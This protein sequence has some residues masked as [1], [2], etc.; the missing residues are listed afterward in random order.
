MD[1]SASTRRHAAFA[2]LIGI[3][4]SDITPPI[5]IYHR[6]WGTAKQDTANDIHHSLTLNVVALQQQEDDNSP[7]ILL[8]ADL[9]WWRPMSLFE[10]FRDRLL[11]EID[12]A[13]ERFIFSLT[14]THAAPPLMETDESLPGSELL[15][16]WLEQ[17]HE[18]AVEAIEFALESMEPAVLE[19]H[20]GR[21]NLAAQR[22][23]PDPAA[24]TDR[25]IC[26]YNPN[27]VADDTLLV[28]RIT[29][30]AG[31]VKGVLVNYACHP[32]TLA[33]Q[34]DCISPDYIG[35]LRDVV[36]QS[37]SSET[38]LIF[39]QGMSGDLAP[40]VQ[41]SGDTSLADRHGRQLGYAV[42][43]TL[44]DMHPPD[45]Q[46]EFE[47]VMESGAPL[48]V[49]SE[50]PLDRSAIDR[51]LS[52]VI[53]PAEL[54]LKD[55]PTAAELEAQRQACSD[56]TLEERLRRKRD[57]RRSLGDGATAVL[58]VYAWRI[59]DAVLIGTAGETYSQLQQQLR[60]QF[61]DMPV[62]A[63]NLINGS[64][65]YLPPAELYDVDVYPVWQTPFDRGCLEQVGRVMTDAIQQLFDSTPAAAH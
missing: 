42:L 57:I 63:M 54:K 34:N 43:A 41:Y 3:A 1:H 16:P 36:E 18:N 19:W 55:W 60:A 45:T 28:G 31:Q 49:W 62:I 53:A 29:N 30:S 22:D 35:A 7:L 48:A 33:W 37:V 50:K 8:E 58:P 25:L 5:G 6:N 39:L 32:T 15:A 40:K 65:G 46:L 23:L 27:G 20:T 4:H 38:A 52:T 56:R 13:P 11:A 59:G 2:G 47:G 14:H 12:L 21:C 61:A 44:E 51:T 24:A 9:G 26:G 10:S 64:I 17:I